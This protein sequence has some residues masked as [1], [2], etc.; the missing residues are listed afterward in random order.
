MSPAWIRP[1]KTRNGKTRYMVTY[2]LHSGDQ[3]AIYSAGTF[4][5]ASEAKTRRDLVGGWLA[6]GLNPKTELAKLNTPPTVDRDYTAWAD[7]YESSRIDVKN[8]RTLSSQLVKLRSV[9][10]TMQPQAMTVADQIEGVAVLAATLSPSSLAGYWAQHARVLDFAGVDPNP[11]RDKTVRLPRILKVEPDPPTATHF[12]RM[13]D[14]IARDRRLPIVVLEQTAMAVGEAATLEWGD[15][16]AAGLQFRLR[17]VNVKGAYASRAR[18]V[19]VPG[20]LMRLVEATC[21]LEDRAIDRQVFPDFTPDRALRWM[22]TACRN[23]KVPHYTPHQLRHRRLSLWHGQGVPAKLLAERAG[24]TDAWMTLNVYSHVMPLEEA[25][26]DALE[27]L[28]V[29]TP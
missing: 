19:Q 5:L 25:S 3:N 13:L 10:G 6:A 8:T 23:A 21:P 28:L 2:R 4:P 7:A 9:F 14:A 1:R 22:T 16:D 20:W 11:A 26:Q 12:L 15:V 17:A 29:M 18:W 27:R 24:H